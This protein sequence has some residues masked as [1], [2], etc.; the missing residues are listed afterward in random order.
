MIEQRIQSTSDPNKWY[1]AR[2]MEQAQ[3]WSCSCPAFQYSKTGGPC[4]HVK[5]L[6]PPKDVPRPKRI[7]R[8]GQTAKTQA[9]AAMLQHNLQMSRAKF[10]MW[11][12][13]ERNPPAGPFRSRPRPSPQ[14]YYKRVKGPDGKFYMTP[15]TAPRPSGGYAFV[16]GKQGRIGTHVR[17]T[18][19]TLDI[20]PRPFFGQNEELHYEQ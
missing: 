18:G 3:R 20:F 15:A 7:G 12:G 9:F 1:I 16:R 10:H 8:R 6:P 17:Y 2:W 4:K 11:C 5:D 13:S 19:S 14:R